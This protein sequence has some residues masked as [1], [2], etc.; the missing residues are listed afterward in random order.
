MLINNYLFYLFLFNSTKKK[1]LTN[2]I[3]IYFSNIDIYIYKNVY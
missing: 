2:L 1:L 3:N